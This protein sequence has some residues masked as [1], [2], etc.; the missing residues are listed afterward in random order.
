MHNTVCKQIQRNTV[1]NRD[2]VTW[3][4]DDFTAIDSDNDC[5]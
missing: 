4:S 2:S 1:E 3:I 5:G